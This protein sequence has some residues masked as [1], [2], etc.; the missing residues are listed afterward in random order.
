MSRRLAFPD[1]KTFAF[2][3]LDDTDDATV[4]NARPVYDLLYSLGFRTTKTVWMADCPEGSRIFF[5]AETMADPHYR[6]WVRE[7]HA[8]GFEVAWHSATME[9]SPRE[10]TEE[11]LEAFYH[12]FG[13]Y[14]A[15]H[16]NHGQ[17]RENLYWGSNRYRHALWRFLARVASSPRGPVYDG[18]DERSPYFWGDLCRRHIRFVRNLTFAELDVR[19][20]DPHTPYR[21]PDTPWVSYWFST[22]D[23]PDVAAFRRLVTRR[24]ID[25]LRNA[26]GVCILSTHFGKGF[27]NGGRVDPD[28]EAVLRYLADQPGWFAPVSAVLEHLLAHG[29]GTTPSRG[30]LF[31]LEAR[32]VLGRL[33]E[34]WRE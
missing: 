15:V 32:H 2:T 27:A 29:G 10:R 12:E 33:R 16:C 24:H 4:A 22:A 14:P 9:S 23:A 1:G 3:M 34:R 7:L 21:L 18:D 28:V 19:A 20:N 26:G 8:R 17:N 6:D 13:R 5:A 25:R 11:A 31:R 30:D